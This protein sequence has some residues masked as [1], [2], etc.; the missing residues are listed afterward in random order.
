MAFDRRREFF[1]HFMR[2]LLLIIVI[3]CPFTLG[4][5][6]LGCIGKRQNEMCCPTDIRKT[7]C[8]CFGED[9]IFHGPCG[10]TEEYYGMRPTTWREWPTSGA[11][12]RDLYHSSAVEP[13]PADRM[14]PVE[15]LVPAAE[16]WPAAV[17]QSAAMPQPAALPQSPIP[18]PAADVRSVYEIADT[19][20]D[21]PF[22]PREASASASLP[23]R[24]AEF[25]HVD[26]GSKSEFEM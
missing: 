21:S 13:P 22:S 18:L 11:E 26:F 12:W 2:Q 10:P 6:R 20:P 15:A 1:Q 8:W 5:C 9:A 3:A 24:P 14:L 25:P 16:H 4:G 7:H 17:P 23:Q 19:L